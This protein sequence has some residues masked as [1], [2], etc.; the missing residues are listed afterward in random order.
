MS[1]TNEMEKEKN[2]IFCID[3]I[4]WNIFLGNKKSTIAEMK[5]INDDGN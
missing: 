5:M 1:F 2:K 4:E 3:N